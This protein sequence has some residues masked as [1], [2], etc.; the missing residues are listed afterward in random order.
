[1]T[2]TIQTTEDTQRQLTLTIEVDETR[3][4]KAMQQKARELGREVRIPG[5]RPGKAPFDVILRRIGEETLRAEAIED[6]IQPVFEEALNQ[7]DIDPYAQPM[8]EDIQPAPLVLTFTV[9]LSPQ[10]TLGDYRSHRKE[11]EPV[12][13]TDEAVEEALEY[14]RVRH[15]VVEPVD[16]PA[17]VGDVVT[18]SGSGKFTGPKP[19]T[20]EETAEPPSSDNDETADV[21][22]DEERLEVLL[23]EKTLFPESPFV[24]NIV[25]MAVGDEKSFSFSFPDP[26]EHEAEYAGRE[27]QFE[28]SLIEVKKRDLPALDDDL[29]KLEGKYE[30]LDELRADLTQS[31]TRQAED[32]A[33]EAL[34]EEMIDHLLEDATITYPPAS[35]ELQIDDMVENFKGRLSRSNWELKDYLNLQGLTEE[36][37]RE[38]FRENAGQQVRRQLALRQFVLDEKLRVEMADIDA[39]IEER[40]AR[41][42]NEGLRDSMRNYYRSGQGLELISSEAL[43]NLVYKRVKDILD[44]DA[45]DLSSLPDVTDM[46]PDEEE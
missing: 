42:D 4:H 40:V 46:L 12:E 27:A 6:L 17:E 24:E 38:D 36:S 35:V 30:T 23:D 10:V 15:Q 33:K 31:L 25:G 32:S 5:F 11:I 7:A 16:R 22:F 29:A 19:V 1:V 9:P 13:V 2:L 20:G 39:L 45:P 3:V 43:S 26:Y 21:I 14:V 8:L 34:I 18:L 28:V 44:G 41:F 37:L